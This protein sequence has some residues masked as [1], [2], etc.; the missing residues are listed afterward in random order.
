[1]SVASVK[2]KLRSFLTK[3][4]DECVV[5]HTWVRQTPV[6]LT[7]SKGRYTIA[8]ANDINSEPIISWWA[9]SGRTSAQGVQLVSRSLNLL[10]DT[11]KTTQLYVWL[12]TC[13]LTIKQ[14]R[15]IHLK[16]TDEN[17]VDEILRNFEQ[18]VELVR[19]VNCKVTFL[20]CPIYSI[21][22]YNKYRGHPDVAEFHG[23]DVIL[24]NQIARLNDNINY[25]N[26]VNNTSI[27]PAF[28]RLVYA[29]KRV[30]N[31]SSSRY[32]YELYVDGIHPDILLAR[33]W[34]ML[35]LRRVIR[36]CY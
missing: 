36:D 5:Q 4:R 21:A 30:R 14:G 2:K 23:Y 8:A 13:D 29:T 7:D 10:N 24:K 20:H 1:M 9:R 34:N 17:S 25:L 15:Y 6:V 28:T 11:H 3:T 22:I 31:R 16:T 35:I 27:S 19:N 18:I 33:V 12:G 26:S 32:C